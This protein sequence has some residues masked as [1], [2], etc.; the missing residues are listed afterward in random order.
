V[1]GAGLVRGA[2]GVG[3][4]LGAVEALLGQV[5]VVVVVF[6]VA[7]RRLIGSL[8]N[9]CGMRLANITLLKPSKV[10]ARYSK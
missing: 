1:T 5:G 4:D 8:E 6:A 2:L 9:K 10:T 3:G 7:G